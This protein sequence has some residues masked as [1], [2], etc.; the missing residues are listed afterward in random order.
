[1]LPLTVTLYHG[2]V[3]HKWSQINTSY[4]WLLGY[5]IFST[6]VKGV[7]CC[8]RE[9]TVYDWYDCKTE[10]NKYGITSRASV[11]NIHKNISLSHVCVCVCVCVCRHVMSL[12]AVSHCRSIQRYEIYFMLL[13]ICTLGVILKLSCKCCGRALQH[14][15]TWFKSLS[16]VFFLTK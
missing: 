13:P 16:S 1:M 11:M 10:E 15:W 12:L 14:L 9:L 2:T 7:H 3:L 8:L 5:H 6:Y 4:A